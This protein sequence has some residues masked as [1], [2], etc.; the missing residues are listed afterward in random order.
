M[1]KKMRKARVGFFGTPPLRYVGSKWQ[2]AEWIIER[3]PPHEV[4]VEPYCG[5]ASVFFRKHRSPIEVLNDLDGDI[6]NFFDVLRTDTD[7]LVRAIELTPYSRAEHER[8]MTPCSDCDPLER[9]RRFYVGLWQSFA[10]TLIYGSGWRH[11]TTAKQRTPVVESWKRLD[12]LLDA[13]YRLK[14]AQ[15]ECLP[16]LE[17][18]EHYDSKTTLFYVDPPYVKSSRTKGS[19]SRYRHEMNDDDHRALAEALHNVK[20]MVMLSGYESTLYDDLYGDWHKVTKT[21]TTNGNST[22]IEVLWLS[23]GATQVD[24]LPLFQAVSP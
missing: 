16:A 19:R 4:Y 23:P 9:A 17:C 1:K 20:G 10:S 3:F 15:I 14:D 6:I 2:I 12:G 18:I 24:A 11:Q 22:S 13:A 7:A 21:S 8:A 5:A